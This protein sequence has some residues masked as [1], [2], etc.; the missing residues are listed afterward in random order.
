MNRQGRAKVPGCRTASLLCERTDRGELRRGSSAPWLKPS[1][2]A[3]PGRCT[4]R[5]REHSDCIGPTFGAILREQERPRCRGR[6]LHHRND[7]LGGVDEGQFGERHCAAGFVH[8]PKPRI[9]NTG[10]GGILGAL[11]KI[12]P[13]QRIASIARSV[14]RWS[15]QGRERLAS[16]EL[17]FDDREQ[18]PYAEREHQNQCTYRFHSGRHNEPFRRQNGRLYR[19]SAAPS[20]ANDTYRLPFRANPHACSSSCRANK[21]HDHASPNCWPVVP[22][23]NSPAGREPDDEQESWPHQ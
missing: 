7:G 18:Q 4:E 1:V 2:I 13:I 9:R 11:D 12:E 16:S 21:R 15:G 19:V 14:C 17:I 3:R 8:L 10:V 23:K 5:E 6:K 20:A 22:A